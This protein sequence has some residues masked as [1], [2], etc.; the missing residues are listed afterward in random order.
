MSLDLSQFKSLIVR[1]VIHSLPLP[2]DPVARIELTTGIMLKESGLIWL[3]QMGGGPAEG[4]GQ[5]EPV[6]HDDL[7]RTFLPYRPDLRAAVMQWLPQKYAQVP[8]PD[9]AALIGCAYYAAAMTALRFY[10]SPVSLPAAGD[11]RA[12]CAAWKAGYNTAG[13]KGRIDAATISIFQKAIN[14]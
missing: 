8:I 5:M 13:G 9:T 12:Q 14:A 6:T 1:P 10:R 4:L 3:K 11:A 7:W 2:G